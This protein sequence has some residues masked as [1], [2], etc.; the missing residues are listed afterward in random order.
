[1]ARDFAST[2][3]Q[4]EDWIAC[5]RSYMRKV[6]GLCERCL[7]RGQY[8]AAD[9]VHHKTPLSPQNIHQPQVTLNHDNLMA[10]CR[11]CHAAVHRTPKRWRVTPDGHIVA[12]PLSN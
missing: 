9:I 7:A 6:G 4:S 12:T 1:M 11:D 8:R 5:R 3:Y 10:L 2:F